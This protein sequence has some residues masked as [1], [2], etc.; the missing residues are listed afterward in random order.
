[1]WVWA[2]VGILLLVLVVFLSPVI[3]PIALVILVTGIVGVSRGS[4][5]WLRL[6]SRRAAIGVTVGAAALLLVTGSVSAAVLTKPAEPPSAVQPAKFADAGKTDATP[7]T[8][9]PT[10]T[11]TPTPTPTLTHVT[12]TRDEV[13]NEEI[14]F[15]KTSVEDANLPRGQT[16]VAVGGQPGQ[17]TLTYTVTLVDGVETSRELKSDVVTADPVTEVTSVGIYDAP[18]PPPPA[19]STCNSNY[20]DACVPIAS[21][22]DCA[23]GEGNGPAYFDG[24]ARVVGTDVYKLDGDGDGYACNH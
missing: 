15:D 8:S 1:M 10:S 5:T 19:A 7:A 3:V 2:L 22:V 9:S 18:A 17:R 14:A 16:A 24:V 20:A 21:D 13:V 11:P 23:G 4:R 12:T 6:K